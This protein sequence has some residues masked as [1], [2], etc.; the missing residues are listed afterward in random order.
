MRVPSAGLSVATIIGPPHRAQM[1]GSIQRRSADACV[2]KVTSTRVGVGVAH[3]LASS[4]KSDCGE[5]VDGDWSAGGGIGGDGGKGIDAGEG[6]FIVV[7]RELCDL[8]LTASSSSR[9][10]VKSA[11]VTN[12]NAPKRMMVR[13]KQEEDVFFGGFFGRPFST[14]RRRR[15]DGGGA[16]AE[17]DDVRGV[18]PVQGGARADARRALAPGVRRREVET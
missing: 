10:T 13:Q 15:R 11:T 16:G 9:K 3:S 7:R 6:E 2:T 12:E 8:L 1:C 17:R 14:S 4:N 5:E 18:L